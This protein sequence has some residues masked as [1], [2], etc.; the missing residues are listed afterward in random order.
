V[1]WNDLVGGLQLEREQNPDLVPLELDEPGD[2]DDEL[3][4]FK[5]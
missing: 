3:A 5:L 1:R 2:A 4:T